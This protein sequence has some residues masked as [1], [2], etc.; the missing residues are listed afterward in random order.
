MQELESLRKD[1]GELEDG[2]GRMSNSRRR[3]EELVE[4]NAGL[5]KE[6][7]DMKEENH[8]LKNALQMGEFVK[9]FRNR[10]R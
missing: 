6:I 4:M 1:C 3:I 5:I 10:E 9:Q 7:A 2:G 8:C